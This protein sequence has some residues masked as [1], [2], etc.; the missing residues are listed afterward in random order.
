MGSDTQLT[1]GW[2][3]ERIFWGGGDVQII[4]QDSKSLSVAMMTCAVLPP[5]HS[6][7]YSVNHI[8]TCTHALIL[9]YTD[10]NK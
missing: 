3:S 1:S 7:L 10:S 8:A 2:L 6:L 4:T 9:S 5:L